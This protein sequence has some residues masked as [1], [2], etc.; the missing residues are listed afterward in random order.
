MKANWPTSAIPDVASARPDKA[1]VDNEL[2]HL[3]VGFL[4]SRTKSPVFQVHDDLS[5]QRV[6]ADTESPLRTALLLLLPLLPLLLPLLLQRVRP[7]L[8]P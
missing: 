4:L 8:L 6:R 7:A 5:R 3:G 2:K 1:S